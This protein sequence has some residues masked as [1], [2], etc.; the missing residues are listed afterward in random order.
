[1]N[2]YD[3]QESSSQEIQKQTH[4]LNVTYIGGPTVLIEVNGVRF[5]TDPTFDAPGKTY[6]IPRV[7]VETK[8]LSG[9]GLEAS[10]IGEIDV[11]LLSHDEHADNLDDIGK[12]ILPKARV[13]VT[14]QEGA[15]R[16]GGNAL[17]LLPFE[18]HEVGQIRITATPGR[19]GPEGCEPMLGHVIGFI[20]ESKLGEFDTFYVSGDTVFYDD[21]S[22][23]KNR[24]QIEKAFLHLG[25]VGGAGEPH[26]TMGAEEAVLLTE[27]LNIQTVIPLHYEDWAHFSEDRSHASEIFE[28]HKLSQKVRWLNKGMTTILD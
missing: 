10:Q 27:L 20:V 18:T 15:K 21:L 2:N 9:P 16:L 22:L 14:T 4:K 6:A 5:L 11:I 12:Q 3:L 25:R 23:I 17:G 13:V 24:F 1:M 26:F 28:K 8:K 19:H 7:G